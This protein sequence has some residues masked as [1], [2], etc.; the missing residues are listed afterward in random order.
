[1]SSKIK[2][3]EII[4]LYQKVKLKVTKMDLQKSKF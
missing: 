2:Y 4:K 3:K 1:M